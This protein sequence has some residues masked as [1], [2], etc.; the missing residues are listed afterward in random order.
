MSRRFCMV[1]LTGLFSVVVWAQGV[2]ALSQL[3]ADPRKSYGNDYP[4]P[5]K[6]LEMTKAP[7]GYTPFYISHYARHG[8]RYYWT[9][10]LYKELDTM[11]VKAHEKKLLTAEGEAFRE[12]YMAAKQELQASV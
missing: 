12:K 1:L 6:K 10:K 5:L 9:D 7:K 2:D 3:K 11:L 8:S 4:Y